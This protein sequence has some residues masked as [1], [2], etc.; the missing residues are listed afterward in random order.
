MA[1][2]NNLVVTGDSRF[3]STLNANA[4]AATTAS[5]SGTLCVNSTQVGSWNEGIRIN[6]S[7]NGWACLVVGGPIN[8]RSGNNDNQWLVASPPT[9][10]AARRLIIAHGSISTQSTTYFYANSASD[11]GASLQI[12]GNLTV[13]GT[14]NGLKLSLV[15]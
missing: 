2:L 6:R 11:A 8:T 10:T 14:I 12:G 15:S 13:N 7:T 4:V 5:M 3:I 1:Q 9:G